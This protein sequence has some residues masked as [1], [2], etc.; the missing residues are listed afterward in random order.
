[1]GANSA[2]VDCF[3]TVGSRCRSP[4]LSD[5]TE[6]SGVFAGPLSGVAPESVWVGREM[7]VHHGRSRR[8]AHDK[9]P[10]V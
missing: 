2:G 3:T 7:A 9:G 6:V 1:M 5:T 10:A 8:S 4:R